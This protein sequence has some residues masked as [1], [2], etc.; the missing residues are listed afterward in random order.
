MRFLGR[1]EELAVLRRENWRGKAELVVVYGRRRVGKTALVEEAYRDDLLWKFEGIENADRATGIRFFLRQLQ[2][3]SS[4]HAEWIVDDWDKALELLAKAL[5]SEAAGH[6]GRVV[7]F[8]DEFQWMCGMEE[9]LV[10]IFKYHWDNSF[11]ALANCVFVLCGSVSSFI[12]K[13][14]VKSRALCGR[15]DLEIDL[16]PFCPSE[17]KALLEG[18]L[19][20]NAMLEVQMIFGGVPQYLLELDPRMSLAQNLDESAFKPT[21]FFFR[22]FER[23]FISHF[24]RHA[25]YERVLRALSDRPLGLPALAAAVETT[26]GGTFSERLKDLE[27]A[28]FVGRQRPVGKGEKSKLLK[29]TLEDEYLHFYF[30]F[31]RPNSRAILTGNIAFQ[32]LANSGAFH[33]WLG[34]AFERLCRKNAAVI[35]AR[36]GFSGVNYEAGPWFARKG[37]AGH[38]A[39]VDLLFR[40][41]D[42]VLTLCETKHARRLQLDRVETG[43]GT[44]EDALLDAFPGYVVERVLILG[45]AVSNAD[46]AKG[47]CHQ[48][49]LASDLFF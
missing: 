30:S 47:F 33:Q 24:A 17:S 45:R 4:C 11:S 15:I 34:Y 10:S 46:S 44:K 28:G 20:A 49:V 1:E 5:S 42:K 8:F 39:Q 21:G 3:Y 29:I 40:R 27:L 43:F 6:S 14:V 7:V 37:L 26:V 13:K 12:V 19:M 32:R 16:K 22:E 2:Q 35:A 9:G 23:L 36:L 31:I 48:V 41:A 18:S 25:V 38:G